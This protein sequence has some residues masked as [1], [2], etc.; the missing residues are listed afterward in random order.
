MALLSDLSFPP[1]RNSGFHHG[2][3]PRLVH[4]FSLIYTYLHLISGKRCESGQKE[5][6]AQG[7]AALWAVAEK[8]ERPALFSAGLSPTNLMKKHRQL[9]DLFRVVF[10]QIGLK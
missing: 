9:M 3:R 5:T 10:V 6:V 8:A 2:S 1:V 4:L 7:F